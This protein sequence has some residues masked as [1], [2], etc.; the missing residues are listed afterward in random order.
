MKQTIPLPTQTR[1]KRKENSTQEGR[2]VPH[3]GNHNHTVGMVSFDPGAEN[4][5]CYILY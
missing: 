3:S 2:F 4:D 1:D 5:P